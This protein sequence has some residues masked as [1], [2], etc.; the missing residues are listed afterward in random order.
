VRSVNPETV[1]RLADLAA[2]VTQTLRDLAAHR[3]AQSG[4]PPGSRP[5]FPVVEDIA[6]GDDDLEDPVGGEAQP[7][8]AQR[9]AYG[10]GPGPEDG[11]RRPT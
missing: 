5:G 10:T 11:E 4:R 2:A 3:W 1:D 8:D 6:V 9:P 7:A